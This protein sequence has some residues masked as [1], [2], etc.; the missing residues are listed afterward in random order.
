MI[1]KKSFNFKIQDE[2]ISGIILSKKEQIDLP[3]FIYLHGAGPGKK[4]GVH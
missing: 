4:E 2:S 3:K 1:I